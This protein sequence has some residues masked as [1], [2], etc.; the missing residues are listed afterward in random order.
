MIV[1]EIWDIY[2]TDGSGHLDMQEM[3][4]FFED[5]MPSM[6]HDFAISD[7]D[8]VKI[9]EDFD[10]DMNGTIQKREMVVFIKRLLSHDEEIK[11]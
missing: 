3:K 6:K 5:F 9:F 2:D 1:N 7:E 4:V 10:E 11:R 8:F